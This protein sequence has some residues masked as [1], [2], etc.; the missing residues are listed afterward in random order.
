MTPP[1]VSARSMTITF[2]PNRA[3]SYATDNPAMPEPTTTR[4]HS[5]SPPSAGL[6]SRPASSYQK[7][8]VVM[9]AVLDRG[10]RH[11]RQFGFR[12]AGGFVGR[13]QLGLARGQLL[14]K[15]VEIE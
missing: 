14:A 4:S 1:I 13:D 5:A 15:R 12:H 11:R 8:L 3:A 7:L 2:Q 6:F 10:L 9:A